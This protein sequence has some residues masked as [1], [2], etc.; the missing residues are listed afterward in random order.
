MMD[1]AY[2]DGLPPKMADRAAL[3]INQAKTLLTKE[4]SNFDDASNAQTVVALATAMMNL[5]A[6]EVMAASQDR[7]ADSIEGHE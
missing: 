7:I 3:Y 1:K 5:E 2:Y 4:L 6:A